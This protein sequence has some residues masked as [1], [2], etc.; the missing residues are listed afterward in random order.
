MKLRRLTAALASAVAL[1]LTMSACGT[2][3]SNDAA[4]GG[5]TISI[6]DNSGSVDVPKN[7]Q[8]V[9]ALD[10][11]TFETLESWGIK[12]VAAARKLMPADNPQKNDDSIQDVGNHREPNFEVI[13]ASKPDLVIDGQ[14]F[15]DHR[16]EVKKYSGDA[17]VV[18]LEPRE[19]KDLGE[20]LKRQT[21]TLGEIFGKEAEAKKLNDDFDA[22]IKRVKDVYNTDEKVLSVITSG[23]NINF[24]APHNGR[25]LGP[26]Y[27][28]LGLTPSLEVKDSSSDHQGDD[29][30]VEA[31]AKSNPDWILVMD[32]DAAVS[33]NNGEKYTPANELISQSEALKNVK[34]VKNKHIL[35]MP[36][37]T[38]LNEG[39]QT[40]T[41]FFNQLADAMEKK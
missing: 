37:D 16:D 9:V 8:R 29:I 41:D 3:S 19:G 32:R 1:T 20:E 11:R 31:I 40:Y 24:A 7:P 5:E 38:Y 21:T 23:G 39:I 27:D 36:Q 14:R 34:A 2:G 35:Y 25:T 17:P 18:N 33:A 12:P 10:N 22:S 6:E 26:A 28:M 4:T 13:V 15:R 30:S